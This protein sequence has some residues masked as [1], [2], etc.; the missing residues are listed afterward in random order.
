MIFMT[1]KQVKE[2]M[3][4]FKFIMLRDKSGEYQAI[5]TKILK[6]KKIEIALSKLNENKRSKFV[7]FKPCSFHEYISKKT[8]F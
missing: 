1:I 7:S 4:N 5:N 2:A 3:N 6:C 8:T